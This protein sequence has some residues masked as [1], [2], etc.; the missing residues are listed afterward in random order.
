[1]TITISENNAKG[2]KAKFVLTDGEVNTADFDKSTDASRILKVFVLKMLAQVTRLKF[3]KFGELDKQ[4]VN[5]IFAKVRRLDNDDFDTEEEYDKY[6]EYMETLT[7]KAMNAPVLE[8]MSTL[9]G[10]FKG[11]S[12][13][14]NVFGEKKKGK[15]KQDVSV[16]ETVENNRATFNEITN[17][18]YLGQTYEGMHGK[19]SPLMQRVDEGR[20]LFDNDFP[21]PTGEND[22]TTPHHEH[23]W[24]R[25]IV[26]DTE[27]YIRKKFTNAGYDIKKPYW[28]D[29]DG[30]ETYTPPSSPGHLVMDT[31]LKEKGQFQP[32]STAVSQYRRLGSKGKRTTQRTTIDNKMIPT[33]QAKMLGHEY[34]IMWLIEDKK[35]GK[36]G[37]MVKGKRIKEIHLL[38]DSAAIGKYDSYSS[39]Q[40]DPHTVTEDDIPPANSQSSY[41]ELKAKIKE[42]LNGLDADKIGK[43]LLEESNLMKPRKSRDK[44]KKERGPSKKIGEEVLNVPSVGELTMNYRD[45]DVGTLTLRISTLDDILQDMF[46]KLEFGGNTTDRPIF[47]TE[48]KLDKT[49]E[50][51]LAGEGAFVNIGEEYVKSLNELVR[52]VKTFANATRRFRS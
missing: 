45:L 44:G 8:T 14:V 38:K 36:R 28:I 50:L 31:D 7:R 15:T 18:I 1:M 49:A 2:I 25:T 23:S 19:S 12:P 40:P 16:H 4:A 33:A 29:S 13:K 26:Y 20:S 46:E 3:K 48:I 9:S 51:Q 32:V 41:T 5:R 34:S 22:R 47:M 52:G 39:T 37:G 11:K 30:E 10:H 17:P 24:Q 35:P 42:E 6:K 21:T 27:D 43:Y